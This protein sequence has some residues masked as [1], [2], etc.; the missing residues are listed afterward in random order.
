MA[1][2]TTDKPRV[3]A[4]GEGFDFWQIGD[5][6][7]RA[8]ANTSLDIHQAPSAKRWECSLSHWQHYRAVYSWAV[9]VT[10]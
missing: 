7:Y 8:L 1:T 10:P 4:S 5:E 6:V 9:D 3:I 2:K